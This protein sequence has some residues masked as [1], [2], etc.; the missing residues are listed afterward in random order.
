LAGQYLAGMDTPTSWPSTI[1]AGTTVKVLRS[2]SEYP[3]SA[4]WT[5]RFWLA[6][7][8]VIDKGVAGV[9]SGAS[10]LVTLTPAISAK[11]TAGTYRWREIVTLSGESFVAASGVLVVE[12][13]IAAAGAGDLQTWEER[14]LA[15]VEAALEDRLTDDM[16]AY[17]IGGRAVTKIPVL[18]LMGL[19]TSLRSAV[20]AQRAPARFDRTVEVT[21]G[22]AG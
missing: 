3:A 17:S 16:Q 13:N 9:A 11:L 1:T 21:F 22:S 7:P 15:V 8:S 14:T 5:L 12:A 10:F 6:G 2:H 18:E 20:E 19:R 4:G